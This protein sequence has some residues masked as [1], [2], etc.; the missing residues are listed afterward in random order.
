[1][2]D[3]WAKLK[4][5]KMVIAT[6]IRSGTTLYKINTLNPVVKKLIELNN[7]ICWNNAGKV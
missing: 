1:M 7:F 5:D 4:K 3:R 6:R 2:S